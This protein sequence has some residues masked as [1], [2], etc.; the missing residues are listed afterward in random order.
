[1]FRLRR[2]RDNQLCRMRRSRRPRNCLAMNSGDK[3][4]DFSL[5]ASVIVIRQDALPK[6]CTLV[7]MTEVFTKGHKILVSGLV[8][9]MRVSI[10]KWWWTCRRTGNFVYGTVLHSCAVFIEGD[11]RLGRLAMRMRIKWTRTKVGSSDSG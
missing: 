11:C 3:E 4:N 1:M 9:R 5:V 7:V 6:W 2:A 10:S 8:P